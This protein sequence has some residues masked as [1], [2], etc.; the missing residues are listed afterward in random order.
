M[1]LSWKT[2]LKNY[3]ILCACQIREIWFTMWKYM[4]KYQN[5]WKLNA[6]KFKYFC[7]VGELLGFY[8]NVNVVRENFKKKAEHYYDKNCCTDSKPC[9][10][11]DDDSDD[12]PGVRSTLRFSDLNALRMCACFHFATH[13]LSLF[14]DVHFLTVV[15]RFI[16]QPNI[17]SWKCTDGEMIYYCI[18]RAMYFEKWE[19]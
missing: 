2:I 1:D 12:D 17:I 4:L 6:S 19:L 5:L 18:L 7:F 10:E 3:G 11:N 9:D 14:V 16:L 13:Y 8:V 15:N